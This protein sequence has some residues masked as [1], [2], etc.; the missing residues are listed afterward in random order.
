MDKIV[1]NLVDFLKSTCLNELDN[2][3][4]YCF[5][6]RYKIFIKTDHVS[7]SRTPKKNDSFL[8][9][10]PFLTPIET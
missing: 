7:T 8:Y 3:F 1:A 10:V 6:Y 2:D 4:N 5:N 9:T